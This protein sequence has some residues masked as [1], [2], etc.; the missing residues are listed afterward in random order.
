LDRWLADLHPRVER[1]V[2]LEAPRGFYIGRTTSP[3]DKVRAYRQVVERHCGAVAMVSATEQFFAEL[4]RAWPEL[5]GVDGV[6]YTICPQV[7]AADDISIMENSW[8]QADTVLTAR[9]RSGG[10]PV[11][12]TS[13]AM[14]GKFGPYPGGV[15]DIAVR[16]SYGDPRQH[17]LFGA[18]WTVSSLRQLVDAEA[19][20]ATYFELS[21]DR[22]L[23]RTGADGD[24]AAPV[25]VYRVLE[26]VLGWRSGNV[27]RVGQLYGGDLVGLGAEWADRSELLLANL[28]STARQVELDGLAGEVT[29]LSELT[30]DPSAGASWAELST[31]AGPSQRPGAV[32]FTTGPYGVVRVRTS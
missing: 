2:V 3:G 14:I 26:T 18:A 27:V 28:A 24:E 13:V 10:R 11:H 31:T 20:S 22:G 12:V 1:V 17:E 15:P 32:A 9:A 25:P 6:G 16:S 21:G 5:A 19:A 4:N 8:G 23:V 7:H 30:N 29:E